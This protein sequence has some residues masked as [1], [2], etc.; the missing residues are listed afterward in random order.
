MNFLDVDDNA[1]DD[2]MFERCDIVTA[3]VHTLT[4]GNGEGA[5]GSI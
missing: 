2:E 3:N 4:A 1:A 5:L